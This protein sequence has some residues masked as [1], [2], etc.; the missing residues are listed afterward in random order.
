VSFP[1]NWTSAHSSRV[2]ISS[3][4]LRMF[5]ICVSPAA[6]DSIGGWGAE[7]GSADKPGW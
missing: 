1:W 2:C 7:I 5:S 3:V 4:V 6:P